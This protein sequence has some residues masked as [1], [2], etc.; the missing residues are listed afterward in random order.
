MVFQFVA[1]LGDDLAL[2]AFDFLVVEL[3]DLA[4]IEPHHVI[5]MRLLSHLEHRMP[6]IEIMPLHQPRRLELGQHAVD[7]GEPDVFAGVDERLVDIFRAHMAIGIALKDF[8]DA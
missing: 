5:V 6:A 3:D 7:S 2:A 1:E 8:Q 4:G